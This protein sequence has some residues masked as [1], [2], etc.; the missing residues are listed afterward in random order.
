MAIDL[1]IVPGKKMTWGRFII[2]DP[3]FSIGIDGY[4][5][6]PPD[7]NSKGPYLNLDHHAGVDRLATYSTSKQMLLCIKM[8]LFQSFQKDGVPHATLR[9]DNCDQDV[10]ATHFTAA[11][12]ERFIGAK[13]EPRL[14]QLIDIVDLLDTTGGLYPMDTNSRI[15]REVNWIFHP[16]TEVRTNGTLERMSGEQMKQLVLVVGGRISAFANGRGEQMES[17]VRYELLHKGKGWIMFREIGADARHKACTDF[18][19]GYVMLREGDGSNHY[20]YSIGKKSKF[21]PFPVQKIMKALNDAEGP[22]VPTV[23]MDESS[24]PTWGGSDII[25]GSPKVFGSCLTP[26]QVIKIV[27][28][29]L[30]Q[31]AP[32]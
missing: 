8:G 28:E 30:A 18:D 24:R 1:V 25:G 19:G 20:H 29:V 21:Y 14:M 2:E 17:D 3:P 27:E 16:Y 10:C 11:N 31:T 5:N 26:E 9:G 23:V 15:K 12:Y 32:A 22:N 4:V 7:F 6:A 13:S